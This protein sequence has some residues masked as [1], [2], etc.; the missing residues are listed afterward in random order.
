MQSGRCNECNRE[1]GSL[2]QV[3]RVC[4]I[5]VRRT[6]LLGV[7]S[8]RV[9]GV[10]GAGIGRGGDLFRGS[11]PGPA[12]ASGRCAR[13]RFCF[14]ASPPGPLL[15][16]GASPPGP[17]LLRGAAPPGPR[18]GAQCLSGLFLGLGQ[19]CWIWCAHAG[20]GVWRQGWRV[21]VEARTNCRTPGD[22]P[23]SCATRACRRSLRPTLRGRDRPRLRRC[24]WPPAGQSP[25][26]G[27]GRI[28]P[29]GS[30]APRPGA[31]RP[32]RRIG[33]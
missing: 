31:P 11:A 23:I 26:L 30:A 17:L 21:L 33:A 7:F 15:L 6:A 5:F 13:A 24:A 20:G 22:R 2:G 9:V 16:R 32:G 10:R 12:F 27:R 19:A 29:R 3:R 8:K 18:G 1:D 28:D 4:D 25:L 14:G